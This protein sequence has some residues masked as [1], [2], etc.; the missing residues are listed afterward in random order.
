MSTPGPDRVP[1]TVKVGKTTGQAG[2]EPAFDFDGNG[3][4][5]AL[6]YGQFRNRFG[7]TF[8]Y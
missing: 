2:F 8:V 6:D 1:S 7:K 4:I 3:T 5:N